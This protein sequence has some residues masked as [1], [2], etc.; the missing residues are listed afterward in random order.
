VDG[1]SETKVKIDWVE[2]PAGK[3]TLG[4]SVPQKDFLRDAVYTTLDFHTLSPVLQSALESACEKLRTLSHPQY[5]KDE[6]EAL[7]SPVGKMASKT[8]RILRHIPSQRTVYLDRFYIA[9]FPATLLERDTFRKLPPPKGPE[10]PHFKVPGSYTWREAKRYCEWVGGR[11]PTAYEWE[12]AARG[13]D[14]RIYP[15]GNEWDPTRGNLVPGLDNKPRGWNGVVTPVDAYS[16]GISPYGIYDMVG[17]FSEWTG[18]QPNSPTPE[19]QID[20]LQHGVDFMK[21]NE[22]DV[23]VKGECIRDLDVN[24]LTILAHVPARHYID[25]SDVEWQSG[26]RSGHAARPVCDKPVRKFWMLRN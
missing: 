22:T 6:R 3:V 2:I 21:K 23:I 4:L 24:G 10:D 1:N 9:R 5:T 25:D 19:V 17:N 20:G 18:T 13:T 7:D 15:W 26:E 8:E 11:L 14:G 16:S 12:K